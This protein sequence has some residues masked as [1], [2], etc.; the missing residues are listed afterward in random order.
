VITEAGNDPKVAALV[1]ITAFAPTE[2]SRYP[3]SSRT[4]AQYRRT[5]HFAAP[6][7]LPLP[8]QHKV[9]GFIRRGRRCEDGAVL[10]PIRRCRGASLR[11]R[12]ISEPAWR[13]KAKLVSHRDR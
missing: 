8:R 9:R 10:W 3:R 6:G 1:Y 4:V 2:V 7:W 11:L 13:S 5:A 12:T